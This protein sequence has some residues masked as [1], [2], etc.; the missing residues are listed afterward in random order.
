MSRTKQLLEDY[1][2]HYPELDDLYGDEYHSAI[3]EKN[4]KTIL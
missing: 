2:F 3:I 4:L 1:H